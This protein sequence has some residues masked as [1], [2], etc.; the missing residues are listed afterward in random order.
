MVKFDQFWSNSTVELDT[1]PQ[2]QPRIRI[3]HFWSNSELFSFDFDFRPSLV[4]SR[5]NFRFENLLLT[6]ILC[7]TKKSEEEVINDEVIKGYYHHLSFWLK[8]LQNLI[9]VMGHATLLWKWDFFFEKRIIMFSL[10]HCLLKMLT[11]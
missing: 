3:R 7:C 6:R 4:V 8:I 1:G 5:A 9:L 2:I 10:S 11:F